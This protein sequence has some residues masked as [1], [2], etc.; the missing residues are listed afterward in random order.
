MS[1]RSDESIDVDTDDA[2]A[3]TLLRAVDVP[4]PAREHLLKIDRV[5]TVKQLRL[6]D[7]DDL[8]EAGVPKLVP[9]RELLQRLASS[10][11]SVA[12]NRQLSLQ[13]PPAQPTATSAAPEPPAL[14][15]P[16]ASNTPS[17]LSAPFT[18]PL[19][20]A[21]QTGHGAASETWQEVDLDTLS[22]QAR[23]HHKKATQKMLHRCKVDHL[24]EVF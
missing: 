11:P 19:Q 17:S 21:L 2:L 13:Q 18:S 6:L 9:R 7:E 23:A 16:S 15:N 8:K 3:Q 24:Q 20:P 10:S 22:A 5:K 14:T 4:T 1:H 12:D